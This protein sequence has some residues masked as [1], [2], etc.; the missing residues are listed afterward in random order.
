MSRGI[1]LYIDPGTGAMLFTTLIGVVTTLSFVLRKWFIKLKFILTRGKVDK[2]ESANKLPIV[3][4]SDDKRYWIVFKSICDELEKRQQ[5]CYYWTS[6]A[7]DPG[8]EQKYSYIKTS[9]I[10]DGNKA[11]AKL[12]IMNAYICLSTTPGLDVYQWRRSKDVDYYVHTS[13][14]VSGYTN[15]RMFGLDFYDAV[16]LTGEYQEKE[17]RTLEKLRNIPSKELY[18]VGSTY[19]D[20]LDK[21]AKNEGKAQK[22]ADHDRTVLLAPSWGA[23]SI[24]N[25]FGVEFL[26]ALKDTGYNIIVRP[27]PQSKT[28]EKDLLEKLEKEF[29]NSEKWHWNYDNENFDA[30]AQSDIMITDYSGVI[31]D[32]TFVFDGPVIYT[33]TELDMSPYDSCWV[34]FTLWRVEMLPLL[35]HRLGKEDIPRIKQVIDDTICDVKN[36]EG[37]EKGRREAWMYR[38]HSAERTADYLIEKLATLQKGDTDAENAV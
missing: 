2:V 8:L 23:S 7:D 21:K 25:K 6:S 3:I 10:G 38:G 34:D 30:L 11:F 14:A 12:N 9:F 27:H 29:P 35:G 26:Q 1:L 32:Y 18:V 15:Y 24:L 36:R 19:M 17:I 4:F 28:S 31:F 33:D 37:R 16:L 22:T 13:H 5:E 20:E